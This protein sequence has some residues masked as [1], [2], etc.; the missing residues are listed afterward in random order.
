MKIRNF[1]FAFLIIFS[2]PINS[3]FADCKYTSQISKCDAALKSFTGKDNLKYIWVWWSLRD[4]K[5]F[6]CIQDSDEARIFQI[7]TH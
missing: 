3:T 4:F 2:F 6:P 7:A 1:I 5:D